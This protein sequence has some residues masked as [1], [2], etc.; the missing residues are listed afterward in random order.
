MGHTDNAD[1]HYISMDAEEHKRR[2]T[3]GYQS[4]RIFEP[5]ESGQMKIMEKQLIDANQTIEELKQQIKQ[6]DEN[7]TDLQKSLSA[8]E[9]RVK[10]MEEYWKG[11]EKIRYSKVIGH[12][13]GALELKTEETDTQTES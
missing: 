2:Y 7:V 3:E 8:L 11:V 9:D 1:M 6:K 4:L 12:P 13:D 10:P 5:S